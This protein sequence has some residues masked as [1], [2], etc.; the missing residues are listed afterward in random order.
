[1]LG[2]TDSRRRL[3]ALLVVFAMVG[4]GLVV[5]LGY[6]QITAR[7]MLV[8]SAHRQIYVRS[9]VPSRRGQIYDRSGTILLAGTVTRD[10]LVVSAS[11][12]DAAT[13]ERMAG[14]LSGELGLTAV[15]AAALRTKLASGKAYVVVAKDLTPERTDEIRAAA[16]TA[17]VGGLS[18][19]SEYA[20]VYADGGGPDAS[21]AAQ[22]I[23]FVNRAG[24]GQYGIEQYYQDVLAGRASVIEADRDA[25]GDPISDTEHVVDPGAPGADLRLTLDADVQALI[26]QEVMAAR[27]A[28]DAQAVSAVVMDPY[29][30]EVYAEATYPS[31]NANDYAAVA[32]IDPRQF[33]DPIVSDVYEPGS[34]FKLLTTI[35][36]LETGTTTLDTTF[37]DTGSLTLDGGRTRIQDADRKAMGKLTLADGIAYS[38]NVIAA[39]VAFGLAPTVRD[40]SAALH[41]VW[42]RLGIGSLTGIDV[43]G[44]ARGI[45]NDPAISAWREIDLA[46]AAFGQGVAV[47]PIQLATA[48][49]AMCNGGVLV[50]PH[51]VAAIGGRSVEMTNRGQVLSPDLTPTLTGL[52]H[53]VLGI[54]WYSKG[55]NAPGFW[56]GG[57]T[58]TA[59]IWDPVKQEW[60]T[61]RFDFSFVGFIGRQVGHPDLIVA[62]R[63]HGGRP[64]IGATGQLILD[65]G[66][67]ELFRRIAT[68][69]I[70]APGLLPDVPVEPLPVAKVGG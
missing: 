2:R 28:D 39:R 20:R 12:M 43:A 11:G 37:D 13:Q 24:A 41:S 19:E 31:Y 9:E 4:G 60:R 42:T 21:L 25:N 35:A 62:I 1:M 45:V 40:A 52:M 58:G 8:A 57:K 64:R 30:G 56:L 46:N 26:E 7:D 32:A 48:F 59:Q 15:E 34:V 17:D 66:S 47:T 16:T 61:D 67:H 70:T 10:R 29:T 51:V 44:E 5:R 49:A 27:I 22:L 69:A 65:V 55:T 68:D 3:L 33:I 36:G 50:T 18:V 38:R 14:F 63:V 53:H 23:G 54:P 6:W